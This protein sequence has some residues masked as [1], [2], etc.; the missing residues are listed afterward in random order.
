MAVADGHR[1][2]YLSDD[3]PISTAYF[4]PV[5]KAGPDPGDF[6]AGTSAGTYELTG[7]F[8]K[9]K[10]TAAIWYSRRKT[11]LR[12]GNDATPAVK[13]K[14]PVF[15]VESWCFRKADEVAEAY[16]DVVAKMKK[17]GVTFC[18]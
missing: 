11:K 13:K 15:A 2:M 1:S 10:I 4:Y 18:K 14:Q 9:E 7:R 16:A 5:V 3:D 12:I 17:A 6:Q 8:T